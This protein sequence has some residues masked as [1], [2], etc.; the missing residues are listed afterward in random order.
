MAKT[1][2]VG[3]KRYKKK[4]KKLRPPIQIGDR[5]H[6]LTVIEIHPGVKGTGDAAVILC[7]CECSHL[8][9]THAA[10]LRKGFITACPA[11][12]AL[13]KKY[14]REIEAAKEV[15][16]QCSPHVDPSELPK[17]EHWEFQGAEDELAAAQEQDDSPHPVTE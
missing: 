7:R 17:R 2:S 1:Y 9:K 16:R 8:V 4:P 10:T 14:V 3:F 5:F 11:D 6:R 15:E 13:E 12:M